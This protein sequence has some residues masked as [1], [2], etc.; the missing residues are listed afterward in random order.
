VETSGEWIRT[1]VG[2]ETR[3]I[4]DTESV[5][6]VAIG[7]GLD[8]LQHAGV[9]AGDLD[10]ILVATVTAQDRSPNTA[11]RVS[12]GIG[13]RPSSTSMP[14]AAATTS[15]RQS[16]EADNLSLRATVRR[17]TQH[18]ADLEAR[19]SE[20]LGEHAYSRT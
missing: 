18:I 3:R 16:L 2:I 4:A 5:A 10:L 20:L 12:A 9:D 11:G 6:D 15:T 13:T 8:A 17:Q 19:L 1:R 14:R 7:A